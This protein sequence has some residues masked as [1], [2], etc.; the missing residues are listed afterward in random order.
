M[1]P[2]RSADRV[3]RGCWRAPPPPVRDHRRARRH[4]PRLDPVRGAP[5]RRARAPQGPAAERVDRAAVPARRHADLPAGRGLDRTSAVPAVTPAVRRPRRR[6]PARLRARVRLRAVRRTGDR[7]RDDLGRRP[8][9]RVQDDRGRRRLHDRRLGRPARDR[10]R[11]PP[12]EQRS[13]RRRPAVP[14]RLRRDPR[15]LGRRA[16]LQPRH[17][18]PVRTSELDAVPPGPHRGERLGPEGARAD[19]E[20]HRTRSGGCRLRLRGPARLRAGAELRR[21]RRVGEQQAADHAGAARQGRAG[22]LLDLLVHQ[23]PPHAPPPGGVGSSVPQAR[24]GDRRGAHAGVRV[25]ARAVE[26]P[27]GREAAGR[28]LPGRDRQPVRHL[29]RLRQP[30]LARRVP[31]RPER[32]S[33]P[34]A[35]R[36]GR[37][38]RQ[39]EGDPHPA[40][41]EAGVACFG[42]APRPR[43]RRAC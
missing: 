11:R 25:R 26:R 10:A 17:A 4:L 41:R 37:L 20:R 19:E 12:R 1:R 6:L 16:R 43:P 36:R 5:A 13:A 39:R 23:L 38:R 33:P 28:P 21:D 35:F 29:E 30:V 40:R 2:A 22:R 24:P 34:R 32:T 14:G 27:L 7:A 15:R 18:G 31:D 3:R 9:V 42:S 8:R